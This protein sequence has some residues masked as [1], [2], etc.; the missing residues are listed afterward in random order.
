MVSVHSKTATCP[1]RVLQ[2]HWNHIALNLLDIQQQVP[3]KDFT[4]N[5][6]YKGK[7]FDLTIV[8]TIKYKRKNFVGTLWYRKKQC[9]YD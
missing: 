1:F 6:K 5:L 3:L 9:Y 2:Q 7:N 8:I 4:A